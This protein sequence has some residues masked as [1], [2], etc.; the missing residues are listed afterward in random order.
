MQLGWISLHRQIQE[1]WLWKDKPFSYGQ[2]WTDM[3]L[4]ANHSDNKF[5]LG[6]DIV[7]VETGSFI[8]SEL[9]L[10]DRW[11][12]SKCKLRR[13]L[14]LLENDSMIIKKTD[15]KKTTITIVNYGNFQGLQTTER[16][17]KDQKKTNKRP[18]KD[19][20]NNVNNVN[21]EN[22]DN[23]HYTEN[24]LLNE[25]IIGFI[26]YRKEIKKPMTDNAVKLMINKLNKLSNDVGEQIEILNQSIIGGYMGVFPL[27]NPRK[28][29]EQKPGRKE[30]VPS[31]M[32]G[33][34]QNYDFEAIERDLLAN[35]TVTVAS[36]PALARRAEELQQRL[37]G[38]G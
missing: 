32:Q 7:T 27:K 2:A 13:F 28:D 21:N 14:M 37:K 25:A 23:N 26:K 12:W 17:I 16:P 15:R 10:M 1:H 18:I 6:N 30:M 29:K 33:E 36:D 22:N 24:A 20:N 9:K 34:K 38:N 5:P 31:W 3:L 4:L 11:G 19:T 8:T 35:D